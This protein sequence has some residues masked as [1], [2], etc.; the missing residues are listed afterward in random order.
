MI[1]KAKEFALRYHKNMYGIYPYSF[2]LNQVYNCLKYFGITD[3]I[4]LAAAWLHDS[5]EDTEL[6]YEDIHE[7]FGKEVADLIFLVTDKR[8]K[9]RKERQEKTYPDIALDQRARIL[10][11]AD[12]IANMTQS[13][14]EQEKMW[15]MYNKEY[16]YFKATLCNTDKL[17]ADCDACDMLAK[18]EMCMW[19]YLD[20]LSCQGH[21]VDL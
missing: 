11:I 2:H 16:N 1:L 17:L 15:L 18:I 5:L 4:I 19:D 7:H 13:Q 14:H 8:G 9:N 20:D 6:M 21:M 10:K 12:R 3:P